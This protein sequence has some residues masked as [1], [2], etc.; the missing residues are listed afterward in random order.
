MRRIIL[1]AMAVLASFTLAACGG[2]SSGGNTASSAAPTGTT[3]THNDA[4]VMFAQ[5]MIPHHQQ[6]V[7]MA[8]MAETRAKSPEVK[9]LAAKIKGA[10]APE[11]QTMTGWLTS[12]GQGSSMSMSDHSSTGM[13]SQDDMNQLMAASGSEFD[14]MFLTMM[15]D[16][17][18][19]AITMAQDEQRNGQFQP[20][21]DLATSI[22]STQQ[23]EVTQMQD[24]LK[25]V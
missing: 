1:L 13:M 12:W 14:K 18:K 8:G 11:I 24:L 5:M 2:N 9:Q 19:S 7:E 17:H 6:A 15:T 10:Q 16:H 22:V 21:K 20:A 4:D 3:S 23:A 25:T